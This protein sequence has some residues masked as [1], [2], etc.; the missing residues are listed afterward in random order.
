MRCSSVST[1]MMAALIGEAVAGPTHIHLHRRA[2]QKK[3]VDWESLDWDN[4][5]IDW[6]S[7]Y[8]AGQTSTTVAAP[9]AVA[10]PTV[11]A[12]KASATPKAASSAADT[13]SASSIVS[14]VAD[15]LTSLL[16]GLIGVSNSR[17]SFGSPSADEG[18]LGDFYRGNCGVPYGSNMIKVSS[19]S[20]YDFTNTFVNTGSKTMI[21]NCWNKIGPD[22]QI[23]S[24]SALAPTSTTLTF[25][26]KPGKSQIVAFQDNTQMAWAEVTDNIAVSGAYAGVWGEAQFRSQG[27]GFDYSA[28]MSIGSNNYDMSISSKENSCVSS[29]SEN[30]WLTA[31]QPIGTSDGSC[32]VPGTTMH[33]TTKMGGVMS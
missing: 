25:A 14:D 10:T 31:T 26:L 28:I 15:D 17:T 8:A 9:V 3:D 20:G 22:M 12:A 18:A 24:G 33:L 1:L 23:L 7:A 4:M 13:V 32:Y 27:S 30:Y 11:A 16:N 6:K 29:Q 19:T 21:I 2:H 5:G